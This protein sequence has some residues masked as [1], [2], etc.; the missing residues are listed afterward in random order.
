MITFLSGGTGTPKLIQGFRK[1]I[2]D[3]DIAVIANSADDIWMYGLYISPDVD[4]L[5][6]L[7]GGL[8]DEDKH[9]GIEGDS[10]YTIDFLRELE[11]NTWFNLGDKD[12][13]LHLFRTKK[14]G[15]GY[16][17][18]EIIQEISKKLDIKATI[19]PSTNSH[20][21]TRIITYNDEDIHFQEF[22]VKH[23]GKIKIKKVYFQGIEEAIIPDE[24]IQTLE[25]SKLVI[26]GPSNPIT[27][28][29]PILNLKEIRRWMENNREKCWVVSPI[30]GNKPIS[31]PTSKLMTI[32]KLETSPIEIARIYEKL[33]KTIVIDVSDKNLE[34]KIRKETN[35]DV[36]TEEIL[37]KDVKIAKKLANTI[38]DI[39]LKDK[40]NFKS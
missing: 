39:G 17:Q 37:F 1:I 2:D 8:L 29:K 21:E 25:K 24:I 40:M 9:W 26:V 16:N 23:R 18:F 12:L 11:N 34:E 19:L 14:M 22:W 27:S 3:S 35:M 7:F 38:L 6:Y 10:F 31:G 32:E 4:T 28:I 5:I 33:C 15:E 20:I 36:I 13:G 30:I